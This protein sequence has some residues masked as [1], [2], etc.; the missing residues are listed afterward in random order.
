MTQGGFGSVFQVEP[1]PLC[2]APIVWARDDRAME[3]PVDAEP[4]PAGT[5]VLRDMWGS[6]P[7]AVKPSA[8]LAF[9]VKLREIHYVTCAKGDTLRKRGR[10]HAD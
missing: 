9:G 1:C 3:V 8:K 5:H 10:S 2:D 7:R 4:S 6:M